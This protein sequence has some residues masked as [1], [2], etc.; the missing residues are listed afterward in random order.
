MAH[1]FSSLRSVS[2]RT[3]FFGALIS[4][5]GVWMQATTQN[6]VVLTELTANSAIAMSLTIGLQL[7][8]QLLLMPWTGLVADRFDRRHVMM[9]TQT[10]MFALCVLLGLL[11]LSGT[12]RLWHFFL[13]ALLLGS[14]NAF[15][16]PARQALIADLVDRDDLPNAVSL[17]SASWNTSRLIGP[18]LAGV[19]ITVI[20][21]GW[22]FIINGAAFLAMIVAL[23]FI[24]P[25]KAASVQTRLGFWKDAAAGFHF[26]RARPDLCAVFLGAFFIGGFGM[27]SPVFTSTMSVMFGRGSAGYGFL[28]SI[29]AVGAITGALM[30]ARRKT[31]SI[32]VICTAA[33]LYGIL[34]SIAA[35]MPTFETYAA[36]TIFTGMS[37]VST[38]IT[39]NS[40]V[41]VHTEDGVRGR[42]MALYMATTM[43]GAP[44]G[45]FVAG[46]AAD[47]F[48]ARW[49]V[50]VGAASGFVA[51][52]ITLVWLLRERAR[53]ES[54]T[55]QSAT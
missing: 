37:I 30:A 46:W 40:Y 26:V 50:A 34:S 49:S 48:G 21:S 42:V 11:H 24:H 14:V 3:W 22:V 27:N 20:G 44:L 33:G 10:I 8:P 4:N 6:W 43:G 1:V 53:R 47:T 36:L 15:D 55:V 18:A 35:M 28:S 41:Q 52:A 13:F 32:R 39:S 25:Q 19:L 45:A 5:A 54:E 31:P 38:T 16:A 12:T 17:N 29:F 23:S 7:G 9:T 2:Y 51:C